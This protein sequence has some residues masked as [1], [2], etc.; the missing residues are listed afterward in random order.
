M[1]VSEAQRAFLAEEWRTAATAVDAAV[2]AAHPLAPVITEQTLY[3]NASDAGAEATRRQTIRGTKRRWF[4]ITVELS[5][6]NLA[7]DLGT[8]ISLAH[9]RFGLAAG[10]LFRVMG[11]QPDAANHTLTLTLWG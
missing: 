6:A 11:V 10:V 4:Q 5:D 2:L 1:P 7:A 8:V 9:P 3:V